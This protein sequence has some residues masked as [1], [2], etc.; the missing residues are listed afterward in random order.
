MLESSEEFMKPWL[1]QMGLGDLATG[2]LK[3]NSS[4]DYNL[5]SRNDHWFKN[6]KIG[7]PI[8]GK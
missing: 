2:N 3:G 8:K 1:P 7:N 6:G 4:G 5:H